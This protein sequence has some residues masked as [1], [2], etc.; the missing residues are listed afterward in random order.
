MTSEGTETAMILYECGVCG[1]QATMVRTAT[2][3]LAWLDHMENHAQKRQY[4][5]WTWNVVQL[6]LS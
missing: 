3:D 4:R 1:I 5:C 6:P 2:G